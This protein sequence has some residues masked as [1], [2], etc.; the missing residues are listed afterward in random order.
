MAHFSCM[1]HCKEV[2]CGQCSVKHRTAVMKQMDIL[3]KEL[4]RCQIDPSTTHDQ[5]DENFQRASQ[6]TL[7]RTQDTV[8]NLISELQEREQQIRKEIHHG[9]E[10]RRQERERR[11]E[12]DLVS[13]R[14]QIH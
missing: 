9:E 2:F 12:S 11:T 3:T 13:I 1:E 8:K 14:C 6:Q 4:R 7:K 10:L 5:I